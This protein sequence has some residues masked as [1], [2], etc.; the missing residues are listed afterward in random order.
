MGRWVISVLTIA[1]FKR[2]SINHYVETAQAAE[3]STKDRSRS[4]GGVG[5]YCS[6]HETRF[7]VRLCAGELPRKKYF[8]CSS[9][10][11]MPNFSHYRS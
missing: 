7:P 4:G 9:D 8:V 6:E 3:R 10:D 1:E 5:A 2:W 11:E